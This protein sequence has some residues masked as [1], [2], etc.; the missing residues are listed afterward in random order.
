MEPNRVKRVVSRNIA[1]RAA[2][3]GQFERRPSV[4]IGPPLGAHL[5]PQALLL[6]KHPWA[7]K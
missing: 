3:F 5:G 2:H 4:Y 7:S 6:G 1:T